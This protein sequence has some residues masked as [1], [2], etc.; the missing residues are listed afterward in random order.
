[1]AADRLRG[2]TRFYTDTDYTDSL[3]WIQLL[4]RVRPFR[5]REKFMAQPVFSV[6]FYFIVCRAVASTGVKGR[7]PKASIVLAL[8]GIFS[9]CKTSDW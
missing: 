4:R 3:M 7:S 2:I 8:G 9:L 1:M 6:L 5:F